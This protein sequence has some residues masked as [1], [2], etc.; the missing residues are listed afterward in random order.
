MQ[1]V[2]GMEISNVAQFFG[3]TSSSLALRIPDS[4]WLSF[5]LAAMIDSRQAAEASGQIPAVLK[6]VTRKC[7]Y[8]LR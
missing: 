1:T 3:V 4:S 8:A 6:D 5:R 7:N 2:A